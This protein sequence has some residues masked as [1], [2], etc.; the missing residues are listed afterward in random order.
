MRQVQDV[1]RNQP[2]FGQGEG[3]N[4]GVIQATTGLYTVVDDLLPVEFGLRQ[5]WVIRIFSRA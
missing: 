3:T 2:K 5:S 1:I 4:F